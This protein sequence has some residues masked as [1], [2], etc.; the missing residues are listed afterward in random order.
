[1]RGI[2]NIMQSSRAR[3]ARLLRSLELNR[4]LILTRT[5]ARGAPYFG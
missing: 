4:R 1:M 3:R 5:G 2:H